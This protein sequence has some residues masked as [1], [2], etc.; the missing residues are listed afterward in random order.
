M[1]TIVYIKLKHKKPLRFTII[2]PE[3]TY[4]VI[5]DFTLVHNFLLSN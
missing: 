1:K 4:L 2:M 5:G 3:V